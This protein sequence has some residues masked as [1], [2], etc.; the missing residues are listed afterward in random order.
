M[1]NLIIYIFFLNL[2]LFLANKNLIFKKYEIMKMNKH[3]EIDIY[4]LENEV[5]KKNII[6]GIIEKYSLNTVLPFFK[7]LI[8]SGFQNCDIIIFVRF[9]SKILI[10][11]LKK[12]GALVFEIPNKYKSIDIIHLRWELYANYLE[13]NKNAYNL[14][15]H[16]DIRD[17]FFQ[18]DVFKYYK[19]NKS[20]LG[21]ALED[22]T[23]NNEMNKKWIIDYAGEQKYKL[24]KN[25]RIICLGSVWGTPDKFLE[26]SEALF[27]KLKE[28]PQGIDQGI[29]NYMFYYEKFLNDCL[30]KSDNSGLVM[31][32]GITNRE[33]LF[34][35]LQDNILNFKREIAAVIHQY[36]RKSDIATKVF[37]KYCPELLNI[38]KL[39]IISIIIIQT[40]III[41]LYKT[42]LKIKKSIKINLKISKIII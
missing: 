40:F 23:L 8:K 18:K 24:I 38:R 15:F 29:A 11:Y 2:Y 16:C 3:K 9:V 12:I 14:V 37:N 17:T 13:R 25:E 6:F 27:K 41:L 31:T 39:N 20:F 7:S 30:I 36:D 28:N 34:F 42:K 22:D 35:D 10:N 33:K 21:V 32:I 1:H 4:S 26:F 5:N 19:T